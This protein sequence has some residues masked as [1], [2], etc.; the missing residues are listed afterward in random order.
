M[1]RQITHFVRLP[2]A[3]QQ[4]VEE[5]DDILFPPKQEQSFCPECGVPA[6]HTENPSCPYREENWCPF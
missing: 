6:P 2:W 1:P 3:T 4:D 5:E